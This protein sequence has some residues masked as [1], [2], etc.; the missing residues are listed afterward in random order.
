MP[1]C[2]VNRFT[3]PNPLVLGSRVHRSD[4]GQTYKLLA[5]DFGPD[6]FF[7]RRRW[8]GRA[9][10]ASEFGR[11]FADVDPAA[12]RAAGGHPLRAGQLDGP[13]LSVDPALAYPRF[14][15]GHFEVAP[16]GVMVFLKR[17]QGLDFEDA[18]R[19]DRA[20]SCFLSELRLFD[21]LR[22]H[23]HPNIVSSH[24]VMVRGVRMVG[25]ALEPLHRDLFSLPRRTF[26]VDRVVAQVSAALRHLHALSPPYR[27]NDVSPANIMYKS[28]DDPTAVLI[29]FDACAPVGVPLI[30]SNRCGWGNGAERSDPRNDW[31]ALE[32]VAHWLRT[33]A[34]PVAR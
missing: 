2:R 26:D 6:Q 32:K 22:A 19:R 27:H 17:P 16:D 33:G 20:V 8:D 10:I 3:N 25:V 34:S 23:L 21:V 24:G 30:K 4:T 14:V 7:V 11:L 1:F 29:D 5:F 31:E 28:E 12:R 18:A 15:L 9:R 13:P